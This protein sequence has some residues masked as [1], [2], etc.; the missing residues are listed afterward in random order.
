MVQIL[1]VVD[2]GAD[3][4][5]SAFCGKAQLCPH[6]RQ[7]GVLVVGDYRIELSFLEEEK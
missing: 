1:N 3:Q 7:N 5:F 6:F 4:S 2:H